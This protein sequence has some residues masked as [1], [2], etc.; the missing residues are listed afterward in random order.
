ML[1]V[2]TGI[3][4]GKFV[5]C[6]V[7]IACS[8]MISISAHAAKTT[9]SNPIYENGA[10]P[11][12]MYYK[13]NYYVATTTW[14]SQ[15]AMRK[16]PTLAGLANAE[17]VNVWAE[18][19]SS[20]CCNF[21]AFEFHRLKGPSGWRWY[22]LYVSGRSGTYDYQHI[23]VL[24][25]VGD[26]PMGPYQYK[27]SPMADS[28]NIDGSY[29]SY[30]DHLY[31]MYSKWDGD[32]Q[33]DFMVELSDPWTVKTGSTPI[34]LTH[35]EYDWERVGLNVNEGPE[36]LIHNDKLFMVYSASY[37]NTPDYKLGMLEL[38]G[39][40]PMNPDDWTKSSE[41]VFTKGNGV[42]GPGHNGFFTSPDGKENWLV[43]HGNA[44][45]SEGCGTTRSLRAQ[46][47]T[48][49]SDGTPNFGEPV[50]SGTEIAVPSGEN[51]P[52]IV[53]PESPAILLTTINTAKK[54]S[55]KTEHRKVIIDP[56]ANGVYRLANESGLYLSDSTCT[57]Q[58][59]FAAW[60]NQDCQKWTFTD[61]GDGTLQIVSATGEIFKGCSATSCENWSLT[62]VKPVA[63]VSAQSGKVL[64]V[65][66]TV[67]VQKPWS[68]ADTQKWQFEKTDDGY[69]TLAAQSGSTCATGTDSGL[70]MGDCTADNAKWYL[71]PLTAG[72]YELVAKATEQVLDLQ[73]CLLND[74]TPISTYS[75]LNNICQRYYLRDIK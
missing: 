37:C 2:K 4:I 66:D 72:G 20:R 52:L 26:D 31:L 16:S 15:I 47:Y 25:S 59:H 21:W 57:A 70:V 53:K 40:N 67:T 24:E 10:D 22:M 42:Y 33:K 13:G 46:P 69:V 50:A 3:N 23:S 12:L 39:S 30:K 63:I 5:Y 55:G 8:L 32:E 41:P 7:M 17:P 11:W 36:A 38:T 71:R 6:L 44:S 1:S 28:Y 18:T 75:N 62:P 54:S 60:K 45:A 68:D 34:V 29:L 35:P 19:D 64:T 74:D 14:S 48:W 51:G 58:D 56:I 43:Y 73:N 61:V 9:F 65:S 27:G 49:N